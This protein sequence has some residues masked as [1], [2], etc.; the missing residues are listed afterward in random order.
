MSGH[1][2]VTFSPKN[3]MKQDIFWYFYLEIYLSIGT[4]V[5]HIKKFIKS[6]L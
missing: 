3:S 5:I 2:K 1:E 6:N 4:N